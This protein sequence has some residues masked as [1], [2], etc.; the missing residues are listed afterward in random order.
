MQVTSKTYW[1]TA[2]VVGILSL[3]LLGF[4]CSDP[5][6]VTPP[7]YEFSIGESQ[8]PQWVKNAFRSRFG[9]V[10]I[11]DVGVYLAGD[12]FVYYVFKYKTNT[13]TFESLL[14]PTGKVGPTLPVDPKGGESDGQAGA[15]GD[16]SRLT[17]AGS[18]H[19]RH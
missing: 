19:R 10:E 14:S 11:L 4:R 2:V 8:T 6:H 3:T 12:R 13:N 7:R 18:D 1:S 5:G 17:N 16:H 9:D 15:I